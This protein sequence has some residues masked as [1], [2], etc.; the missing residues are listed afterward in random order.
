MKKISDKSDES[1]SEYV[2]N[3]MLTAPIAHVAILQSRKFAQ[4]NPVIAAASSAA[5]LP[6]SSAPIQ[7]AHGTRKQ[8][9]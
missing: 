2:D 3:I 4:G 8:S 5:T 9:S 6:K 1:S 7:Q